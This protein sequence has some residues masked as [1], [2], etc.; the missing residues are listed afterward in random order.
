MSSGL[1]VTGT[2][3][4]VGKTHVMVALLRELQGAGVRVG[5]YKPACSG[6]ER[7]A[8]GQA[9]WSDIDRLSAALESPVAAERISPQRYHAPL[10]PPVAARLEGREVNESQ[11][12]AGCRWW[13]E[14]VD[15]L[16]VEGVGGLLCPLS[17]RWTVADFAAEIGFPLL[18]VAAQRLGVIN[19]TLLTVEVAR[20]RGL[21]IAGIIMNEVAPVPAEFRARNIGEINARCDVPI[22][23]T[24]SHGTGAQLH[25]LGGTG[26]IDWSGSV[27]CGSLPSA[28]EERHTRR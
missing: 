18:I 27:Q 4:D 10:A 11:L 9:H 2:D 23:A 24:L 7:D 13:S 28:G 12:M 16:L 1:F 14:R 17:E 25:P 15:L 3:T 20:S 5:A 19:H 6:S 21:P 8:E 26:K 22:L